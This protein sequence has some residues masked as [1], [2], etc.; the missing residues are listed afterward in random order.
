MSASWDLDLIEQKVAIVGAI[1]TKLVAKVTDLDTPNWLMSFHVTNLHNERLNAVIVSKRDASSKNNR[2][3]R[4]DTECTRP[5]L[6][7]FDRRGVDCK[8]LSLLTV[9]CS[10]LKPSDIRA[11]SKLCLSVAANH[12]EVVCQG[13]VV[14]LLFISAKAFERVS[15]HRLMKGQWALAWEQIGPTEV[16]SLFTRVISKALVLFFTSHDETNSL[17]PDSE[18]L[19]SGHLVI[20]KA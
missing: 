5:E 11:M 16:L 17:P 3:I 7:S 12:I 18:L 4:L 2:M 9:R 15:E 10:S 6:G 8:S 19:L 13:Q 1:V 20:V 14:S